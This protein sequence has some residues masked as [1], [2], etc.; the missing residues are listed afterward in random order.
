MQAKL[1]SRVDC[2]I[3]LPS[4]EMAATCKLYGSTLHGQKAASAFLWFSHLRLFPRPIPVYYSA[5]AK[6]ITIRG[7][8]GKIRRCSGSSIDKLQGT[9]A[10]GHEVQ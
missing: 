10:L 7:C 5:S 4:S 9:V 6:H 2:G 3:P 1:I 8:D